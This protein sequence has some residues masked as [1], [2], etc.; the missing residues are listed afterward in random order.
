M[1]ATVTAASGSVT[2]TATIAAPA[3]ATDPDGA[4]DSASDSDTVTPAAT[5]GLTLAKSASPTTYTT[6]GDVIT[7]TYLLTN[8][9][10]VALSGP[11]TVADDKATVTCPA[12]VS[13]AVGASITCTASYTIT[14]ADVTAGS[15]T[16][17]A[18]AS[19]ADGTTSNQDSATVTLAGSTPTPTPTASPAPTTSKSLPPTNT[20]TVGGS[21]GPGSSWLEVLAASA[22]ILAAALVLTSTWKR[23]RD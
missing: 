22:G 14:A 3:G 10:N 5:P 7:Y 4:N 20:Q 12:T 21:S 13:L 18:T 16:N 11:F 17:L 23:R 9:G 8:S 15:V 6:A 19:S 2:N 1:T